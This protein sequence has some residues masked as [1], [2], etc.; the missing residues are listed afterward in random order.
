[1][2]EKDP[3]GVGQHEAGAK[4]D[5]GKIDGS[6]L[7]LFSRALREVLRVGTMGAEKYTYG[8]WLH[9]IQG[10]RRYTAAMQRHYFAEEVEGIFDNDP[11]YDTEEGKKWKGQIRHDAQV[12]WNALARLELRL[13]EEEARRDASALR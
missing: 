11:Y 4:L 10:H 1:M 9:V 7:G 2:Q 5:D 12:A 8:G 13:R 3:N 6:L